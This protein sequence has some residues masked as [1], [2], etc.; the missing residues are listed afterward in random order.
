MRMGRI[1]REKRVVALMI[2]LYCRRCEGNAVLC[3]KCAELM[4]YAC[5]RLAR[6]PHGDGK[7]SCRRCKI[8][9]YSQ[10][11]RE[12]MRRVMRYSGPRM[13]WHHPLAA[14]IHMFS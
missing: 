12:R 8:H 10:D 1:E 5:M 7:P 13:L 6:C 4:E 2:R 9:C 14:I 11:M 3:E